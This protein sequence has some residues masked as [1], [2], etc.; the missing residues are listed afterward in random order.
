MEEL[1]EQALGVVG[2]DSAVSIEVGVELV[3]GADSA[4]SIEVG[5][6]LVAGVGVGRGEIFWPI[7]SY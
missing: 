6:E 5:V 4:V 2:A 7:E 1:L 3:V